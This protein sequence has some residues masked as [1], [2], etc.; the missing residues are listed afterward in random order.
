MEK[1]VSCIKVV[2]GLTTKEN[3]EGVGHVTVIVHASYG[4]DEEA[5][6]GHQSYTND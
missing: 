4:A 6:V 2:V 1:E 5:N 3:V